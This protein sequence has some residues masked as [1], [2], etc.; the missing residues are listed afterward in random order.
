M[1]AHAHAQRRSH[2][3]KW[4][5]KLTSS[6]CR[7]LHTLRRMRREGLRW[8]WLRGE[9]GLWWEWLGG[10]RGLWWFRRKRKWGQWLSISTHSIYTEAPKGAFVL[11]LATMKWIYISINADASAALPS[12]WTPDP[13]QATI[14][15]IGGDIHTLVSTAQL[16]DSWWELPFIAYPWPVPAPCGS[17]VD[18]PPQPWRRQWLLS[19]IFLNNFWCWV[20]SHNHNQ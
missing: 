14:V 9:R 1:H 6:H 13:T 19:G 17:W 15:N 7:R 12:K 5:R 18:H 11:T 3:T 20:R 10:E 4:D 8:E 2:G 16:L